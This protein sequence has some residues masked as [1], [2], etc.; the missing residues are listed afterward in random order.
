MR[1]EGAYLTLFLLHVRLACSMEITRY[2]RP[3][4][5]FMILAW[6]LRV[7]AQAAT[8]STPVITAPTAGQVLHGPVAVMGVTDVPNFSSAEVSF[9]YASD[10]TNTWFSISATTQPIA[11]DVL[12][13]WDTT[14]IS[15]GD[16]ILRLRVTLQDGTFQDVTVPV[17]VRNYTALATPTLTATATVPAL[18]IPTPILVAV[19]TPTLVPTLVPY[20]TPTNLPPNPAELTQSQIYG[21]LQRG[22]ITIGVLFLLFGIFLR[23][24]RS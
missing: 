4:L 8:P 12:A 7:A 22:A 17:E 6:P 10:T 18:Q 5:F 9:S 14:T 23:L 15:D 21:S 20:S 13:S 11:N 3:L 1:F 16:Y 24:R 19:S 2:I